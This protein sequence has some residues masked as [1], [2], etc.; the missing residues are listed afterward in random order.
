MY[1]RCV[2]IYKFV[3]NIY[4]RHVR[5]RLNLGKIFQGKSASYGPGNT[6]VITT[7]LSAAPMFAYILLHMEVW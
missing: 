3:N 7:D 1:N 4:P 5:C 6:V 2:G